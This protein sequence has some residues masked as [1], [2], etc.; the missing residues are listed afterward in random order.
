[1]S[2]LEYLVIISIPLIYIP[3]IS[4]RTKF[5]FLKRITTAEWYSYNATILNNKCKDKVFKSI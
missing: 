3:E 5:V 4:V 2:K 1:M